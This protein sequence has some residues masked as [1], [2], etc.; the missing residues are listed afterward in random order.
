MPDPGDGQE[1]GQDW[2]PKRGPVFKVVVW[3]VLVLIAMG[4]LG[5]VATAVMY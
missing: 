2:H 5:A 4:V 3:G 1:S